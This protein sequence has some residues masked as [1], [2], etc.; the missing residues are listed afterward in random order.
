MSVQVCTQPVGQNNRPCIFPP[1]VVSGGFN[2]SCTG[3]DLRSRTQR[4]A[5]GYLLFLLSIKVSDQRVPFVDQYDQFIQQQLLSSLLG[6]GLLPVCNQRKNLSGT[7][8]KRAFLMYHLRS[9]WIG[10]VLSACFGRVVPEPHRDGRRTRRGRVCTRHVN[11]AG[12]S[13][14]EGV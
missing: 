7:M 5:L 9:C 13:L 1:S 2:S 10:T 6:L 11:T 14:Y 3:L 8:S 4:F 12:P